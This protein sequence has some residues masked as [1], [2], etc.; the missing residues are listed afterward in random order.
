MSTP[1]LADIGADAPLRYATPPVEI[2]LLDHGGMLE[3]LWQDGA[4]QSLTAEC[5]RS[6]CRCAE[7]KSARRLGRFP[8]KAAASVVIVD[9]LAC[10]A[11]ALNLHF[12]DGHRR[13][14]FPFAWLASIDRR[15]TADAF[16]S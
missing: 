14:I 8:E 12:S 16:T 11:G 13:G 10:G 9:V 15:S 4:A 1:E 6:L 5:L 2:R 7:C 3:L